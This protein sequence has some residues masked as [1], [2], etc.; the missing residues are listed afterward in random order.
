MKYYILGVE[1]N[2]PEKELN[3]IN[4]KGIVFLLDINAYSIR[5]IVNTNAKKIL[6]IGFRRGVQISRIA[7]LRKYKSLQLNEVQTLNVFDARQLLKELRYIQRN[8]ENLAIVMEQNSTLTL[9][10]RHDESIRTFSIA[11]ENLVIDFN[12]FFRSE[13]MLINNSESVLQLRRKIHRRFAQIEYWY[14]MLSN[15]PRVVICASDFVMVN[16]LGIALG[17]TGR[18]IHTLYKNHTKHFT[19]TENKTIK[20]KEKNNKIHRVLVLTNLCGKHLPHLEKNL[21]FYSKGRQGFIWRHIFGKATFAGYKRE[22]YEKKYDL[23]IY[24]GHARVNLGKIEIP[25]ADG[26]FPLLGD[27]SQG[28]IHLACLEN[29]EKNELEEIP[30]KANIL[31]KGYVQDFNDKDFILQFLDRYRETFSFEKAAL[32]VCKN[33]PFGYWRND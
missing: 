22:L 7:R 10:I 16:L 30:S 1:G 27:I 12:N 24:R 32:W 14:S 23:V 33:S 25:L 15:V 17:D 6:T 20:H 29:L 19:S 28:Y 8:R 13:M 21:E 18:S 11:I 4:E 26:F 3:T 9:L 31:P 2:N 5:G